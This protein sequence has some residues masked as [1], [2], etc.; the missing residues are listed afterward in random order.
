M[1]LLD[2]KTRTER[3]CADPANLSPPAVFAVLVHETWARNAEWCRENSD[4]CRQLRD[5]LGSS[6]NF[7]VFQWSGFNLHRARIIAGSRL[8]SR[9][10]SIVSKHPDARIVLIGH[11]HGGNVIRYALKSAEIASRV[12]GVVTLATPFIGLASRPFK[13]WLYLMTGAF[14]ASALVLSIVFAFLLLGTVL[15]H[16]FFY[17]K[18]IFPGS[19]VRVFAQKAFQLAFIPTIAGLFALCLWLYVQR[20]G[21]FIA[22]IETK[23]GPL[24]D[25][26]ITTIDP[27]VIEGIPLLSIEVRADEARFALRAASVCSEWAHRTVSNTFFN[28][29]VLF[30]LLP[31]ATMYFFPLFLPNSA[32]DSYLVALGLVFVVVPLLVGLLLFLSVFFPRVIK[33]PIFGEETIVQTWLLQSIQSPEPVGWMPNTHRKFVVNTKWWHSWRT[34]KHS[35]VYANPEVANCVA[36]WVNVLLTNEFTGPV[37][38]GSLIHVQPPPTNFEEAI[39]G[40]LPPPVRKYF[41]D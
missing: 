16:V 15:V 3:S 38:V 7:D 23:L 8:T 5:S 11:S 17:A 2:S 32:L 21:R 12:T 6:L 35:L 24:Q 26:M 30:A 22:A 31:L 34:I 37:S 18:T 10:R 41:T 9:L 13:H 19:P 28:G 20:I 25:E 33:A 29:F 39:Y 4:F 40:V 27:P 14:A 36:S 1:H